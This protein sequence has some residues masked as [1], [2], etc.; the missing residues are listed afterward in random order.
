MRL[1]Q[2]ADR[3]NV[4]RTPRMNLK[5]GVLETVVMPNRH[6]KGEKSP[7]N[8]PRALIE[9]LESRRLLAATLAS[10]GGESEFAAATF[11]AAAGQPSVASSN[12]VNGATNIP[13]YSPI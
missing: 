8:M 4:V 12:P 9:P 13:R 5:A 3:T 2:C 11:V 1:S 10:D 6:A 7:P